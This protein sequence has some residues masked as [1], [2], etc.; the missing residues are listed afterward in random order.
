MWSWVPSVN[1]SSEIDQIPLSPETAISGHT[2]NT[3]IY[4]DTLLFILKVKIINYILI[5]FV[6]GNFIYMCVCN[7]N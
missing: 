2:L 1:L 7:I 6:V 4:I 3:G 5:C